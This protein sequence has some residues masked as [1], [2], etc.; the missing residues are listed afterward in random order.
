MVPCTAK[1]VLEKVLPSSKMPWIPGRL[2]R[3]SLPSDA[4]TTER[5]CRGSK[6]RSLCGQE[7]TRGGARPETACAGP[8]A[9]QIRPNRFSIA[10][11]N[12]ASALRACAIRR[13]KVLAC[14]PFG[15]SGSG[16]S[17]SA[18][19]DTAGAVAAAVAAARKPARRA[20]R[21]GM[22]GRLR[23]ISRMSGGHAAGLATGHCGGQSRGAGCSAAP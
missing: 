19:D 11:N 13:R 8:T 18:R 22:L 23:P 20:S 3:R 17:T 6:R 1:T 12:A 10:A 4:R 15:F 16:S 21:A 9:P 5:R 14:I 7:R 2:P